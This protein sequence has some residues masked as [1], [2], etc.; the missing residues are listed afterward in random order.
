MYHIIF[1]CKYRKKLLMRYGDFIKSYFEYLSSVSNFDIIKMEVDKDHIHLLIRS[2]PKISVLQIVN[3]LKQMSTIAI[4]KTYLGEL[5]KHFWKEHT[6]WSDGYFV[7][8]I[9]NVS[10]ETVERYIRNQG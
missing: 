3:R 6:F 1:V 7:C 9:G 10:K 8:S 2:E 5:S 4:W